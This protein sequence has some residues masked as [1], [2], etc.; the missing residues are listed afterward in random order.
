MRVTDEGEHFECKNDVQPTCRSHVSCTTC[1][2]Q[3]KRGFVAEINITQKRTSWVPWA[4]GFVV[5]AALIWFVAARNDSSTNTAAR[6]GAYDTSSAAGT[7][8]SPRDSA[9][10]RADSMRIPPR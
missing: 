5:L 8:G 6:A 4:L 7:L 10:M 3:H 1:E 2:L 9:G